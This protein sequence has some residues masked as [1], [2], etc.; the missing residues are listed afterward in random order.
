MRVDM[1]SMEFIF[2]KARYETETIS[3][4]AYQ[5]CLADLKREAAQQ[6][7]LLATARENAVAAVEALL[8]PWVKQYDGQYT[9]TIQ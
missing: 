2:H 9:V 5:A 7:Q 4:E 8:S 6:G 1:G 3:Q